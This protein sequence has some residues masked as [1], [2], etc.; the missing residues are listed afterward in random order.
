MGHL[1]P[2]PARGLSRGSVHV[3]CGPALPAVTVHVHHGDNKDHGLAGK[4]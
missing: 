2:L 4:A 3:E 1:P